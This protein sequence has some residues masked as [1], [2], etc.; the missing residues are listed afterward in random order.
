MCSASTIYRSLEHS[1]LQPGNWAVFPGGGGG[2]GI[3]GVQLARAMGFRPIAIDAGAAKRDLCFKMGA[4]HFVDFRETKDVAKEVV[5]LTDGLGA[6]GVFVTAPQAY[7]NAVALVG[8]RI[9]SKIMCIGLREYYSRFPPF[10]GGISYLT[11]Y[12]RTCTCTNDFC[13]NSTRW[14]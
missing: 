6:H 2:V 11:T 3:Q 10:D 9:N 13:E 1:G 14:I 7:A 12:D 8:K 5:R 4:E